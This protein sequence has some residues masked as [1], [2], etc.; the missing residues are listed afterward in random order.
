MKS[1]KTLLSLLAVVAL[2]AS[3]ALAGN[4][5]PSGAHYNLN[6]IGMAADDTEDC[7]KAEMENSN[8]HTIFVDLEFSDAT[9]TDPTPTTELNRRNKIFLQEGPFQVIDGNACDGDEAIFQL[10]ANECADWE[11][12]P[13]SGCDYD[14]Y[15]RGLGS[16]KG[17]PFADITTC[18]IDEATDEF[19]CSIE[20]VHVE[21][22]KGKSTFQ[23]VTKELT[24]LCLDTDGNG[25]CDTR[26]TLFESEFYQ[27]FWDYDN[28]GLRLAQLRFY[29]N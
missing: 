15:V 13:A 26:V 18:R 8:R 1:C 4:G 29:T 25:T 7:K 6:I 17:D 9:P 2:F 21:R 27:Y 11:T 14:V 3:A 24:S 20:T 22:N 28:H 16:P 19:Q 5:A 23:N 12:D 10:P